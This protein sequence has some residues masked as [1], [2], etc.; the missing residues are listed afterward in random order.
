MGGY[1]GQCCPVRPLSQPSRV[2]LSV[3]SERSIAATKCSR[4]GGLLHDYYE[5]TATNPHYSRRARRAPG[6]LPGQLIGIDEY[7][8]ATRKL[9]TRLC[10][11]RAD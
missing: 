3:L 2:S 5:P 9:L 7:R 6:V 1:N 4:S 11:A 8:L 10:P